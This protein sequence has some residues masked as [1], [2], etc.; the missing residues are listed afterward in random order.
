MAKFWDASEAGFFFKRPDSG[1]SK[2][3]KFVLSELEMLFVEDKA[4]KR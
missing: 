2:E 4:E 3:W 1:N